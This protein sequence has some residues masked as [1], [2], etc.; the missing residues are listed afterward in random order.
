MLTT[1]S[2]PQAKLCTTSVVLPPVVCALLGAT[3]QHKALSDIRSE[4]KVVANAIMAHYKAPD[5]KREQ[6]RRYLEK[7][8]VVDSLTKVL[9]DLYEKQEKPDNP[10]EFVKDNLGTSSLSQGSSYPLQQEVIDLRQ[11]CASLEEENK[12]LRTKLLQYEPEEK[13]AE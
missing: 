6:F 2:A 12:Q 13:A 9:V 3:R 10:L 1:F 5:S 11:K 7:A 4:L 8:G